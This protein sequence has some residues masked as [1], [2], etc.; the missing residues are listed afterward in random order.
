MERN[1]RRY[2][3]MLI[4][5]GTGVLVFGAW[6]VVKTF[7]YYLMTKDELKEVINPDHSPKMDE[8][9]AWIIPTIFIVV[10]VLQVLIDLFIGLRAKADGRGKKKIRITYVVVTTIVVVLYVGFIALD[11]MDIIDK[12][13]ATTI[14]S[15]L[16]D[17][18]CFTIFF[19]IVYAAVNLRKTKKQLLKGGA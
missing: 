17:I 4:V 19:E 16:V 12:P 14:A 7:L 15:T 3:N 11:I 1:K 8:F 18:T 9:S 13:N 5:S 6:A 10:A 2:E